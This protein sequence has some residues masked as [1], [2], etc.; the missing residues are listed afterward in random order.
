MT[1][2]LDA[3]LAIVSLDVYG[4]CT[5]ARLGLKVNSENLVRSFPVWVAPLSPLLGMG[6]VELLTREEV[7]CVVK[8]LICLAITSDQ[9]APSNS[10]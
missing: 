6:R 8:R 7:R 2:T 1:V 5:E 4:S 3:E 10:W 9:A